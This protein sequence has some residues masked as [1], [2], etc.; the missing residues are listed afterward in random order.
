MQYLALLNGG[1]VTTLVPTVV[2][3]MPAPKSATAY[4]IVTVRGRAVGFCSSTQSRVGWPTTGGF[5][6]TLISG[7]SQ[8]GLTP[9]GR[10]TGGTSSLRIPP[11]S[12]SP[13]Q[14][15]TSIWQPLPSVTGFG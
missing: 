1:S 12:T 11:I 3:P 13:I 4:T 8:G 10:C 9:V 7:S 14:P 2:K 15:C 5:G 6:S